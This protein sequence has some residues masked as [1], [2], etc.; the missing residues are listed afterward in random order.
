M[1]EKTFMRQKPFDRFVKE[2]S[3]NVIVSN[4]GGKMI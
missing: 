2:R 1:Q 4:E 3:L